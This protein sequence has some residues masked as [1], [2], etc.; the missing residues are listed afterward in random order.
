M[1]YHKA[2]AHGKPARTITVTKRAKKIQDIKWPSQSTQIKRYLAKANLKTNVQTTF[3]HNTA[4][5]VS[6]MTET[7][8]ELMANIHR[9]RLD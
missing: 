4:A 1:S 8:K 3:D 6:V 2:R 7:D 9:R 5:A